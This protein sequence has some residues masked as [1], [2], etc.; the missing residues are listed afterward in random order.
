MEEYLVKLVVYTRE[1]AALEGR[2]RA[3]IERSGGRIQQCEAAKTAPDTKEQYITFLIP[4][5]RLLPDVVRA[6][7]GVRGAAV[8]AVTEPRPFRGPAKSGRA[9]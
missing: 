1:D 9:T 4:E 3:A 8:M 7:E 5:T 6:V 2:I